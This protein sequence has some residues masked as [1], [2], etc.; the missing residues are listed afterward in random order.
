MPGFVVEQE[1][2]NGPLDLLL[3][4]IQRDELDITS[5]SL[6]QVTDGFL[7]YL[8]KNEDMPEYELADFLMIASRLLYLKSRAILPAVFM[9]EEEEEVDLAA[10]LRM[11]KAF[12]EASKQI[13]ERITQGKF[14]HMRQRMVVT[15]DQGFY[16]PEEVSSEG[17]HNAFEKVINRLR[18]FFTLSQ[19]TIK[20]VKSIK[21]TI[22]SIRKFFSKNR[23]GTFDEI[24]KNAESKTDVI[25]SFVALLELVKQR[26]VSV[27]QK[28][29]FN[30][31]KLERV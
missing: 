10:Q 3:H 18:P 5:V 6:A 20:K 31:I 9:P 12:V 22:K 2:F 25:M 17:I 1:E 8:D 29:T 14:S 16:P 24:I 15:P 7:S 26:E 13:E 19:E 27:S 21:E 11:Y 23:S 4:L 28:G 30:D